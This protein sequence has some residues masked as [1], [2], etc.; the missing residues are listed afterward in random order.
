MIVTQRDARRIIRKHYGAEFQFRLTAAVTIGVRSN[1]EAFFKQ[2]L[3]W[4]KLDAGKDSAVRIGRVI[5]M[6]IQV[7]GELPPVDWSWSDDPCE[8][9]LEA[10]ILDAALAADGS[11]LPQTVYRNSTTSG[12]TSLC[13]GS[14]VLERSE[15]LVTILPKQYFN[16]ADELPSA[17]L[18]DCSDER[19]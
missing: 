13:N 5:Q 4:Q 12:W 9:P 11:W 6:R 10:A 2:T 1:A 15:V 3:A 18:R 14:R 19:M 7:V 17:H 16:G 8:H